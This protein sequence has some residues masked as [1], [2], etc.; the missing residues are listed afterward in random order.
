MPS[1]VI[2]AL[3]IGFAED[4][5]GPGHSHPYS[6]VDAM[7]RVVRHDCEHAGGTAA[8]VTPDQGHYA[9]ARDPLQGVCEVEPILVV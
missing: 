6:S 7:P 9:S 5:S 3:H 4:P 1:L 2:S 8:Q